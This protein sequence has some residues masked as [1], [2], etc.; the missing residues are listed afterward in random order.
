MALHVGDKVLVAATITGITDQYGGALDSGGMNSVY[1][2]QVGSGGSGAG[3]VAAQGSSPGLTDPNVFT[4]LVPTGNSSNF[5]LYA[6]Q[7]STPDDG[8]PS[9]NCPREPIIIIVD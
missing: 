7:N 1:A 3:S 5:S 2:V 6:T 9:G 4:P 8:C